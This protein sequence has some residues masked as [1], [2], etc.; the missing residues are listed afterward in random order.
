MNRDIDLIPSDYRRARWLRR[1]SRQM[2]AAAGVATVACLLS[3]GVLQWQAARLQQEVA[4][5]EK[6][7]AVTNQQRT[8]LEELS[9]R[10]T[11]LNQQLS[12][13]NSLRSGA[14]ARS[15]FTAIDK[16]LADAE[17]W[18]LNWQF[19]R[20]G[21]ILPEGQS[22][23]V[24]TGYFIVIPEGRAADQN[25]DWM[26]ETHMRITGQARNHETLSRFVNGLYQ[27]P[28]VVEVSVQKTERR[29][30]NSVAVVEFDLAIVLNSEASG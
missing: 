28:T 9:G 13:L 6:Q 8:D 15:V 16:A 25:E 4:A 18:F 10:K 12:M 21:V 7:R 19:K 2:I 1:W 26:V 20:A 27:Q 30:R 14:P 24:E 11:S 22:G 5:L 29:E 17:I 23:G 3:F